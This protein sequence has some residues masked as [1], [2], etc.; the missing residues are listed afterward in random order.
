MTST[1]C[2]IDLRVCCL[3]RFLQPLPRAFCLFSIWKRSI[4]FFTVWEEK[5]PPP[6][7]DEVA[8]SIQFLSYRKYSPL[9]RN[10]YKNM[11]KVYN[12]IDCKSISFGSIASCTD[13]IFWEVFAKPQAELHSQLHSKR[14]L[15]FWRIPSNGKKSR[16]TRF[17]E[18]INNNQ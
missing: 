2:K 14:F 9:I 10:C 8:T 5:M 15:P 6:P 1:F 18:S 4:A 16:Q 3:W 17:L 11:F 12:D 13:L 7:R